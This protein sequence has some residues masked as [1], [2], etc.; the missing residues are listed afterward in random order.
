MSTRQYK[1]SQPI[2]ATMMVDGLLILHLLKIVMGSIRRLSG[3][4]VGATDIRLVVY[5]NRP[6]TTQEKIRLVRL[7]REQGADLKSSA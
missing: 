3:A 4:I 1:Q 6:L 2:P 5:S 7:L